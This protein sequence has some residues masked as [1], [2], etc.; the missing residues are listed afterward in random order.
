MNCWSE[1]NSAPFSEV[2]CVTEAGLYN[3]SQFWDVCYYCPLGWQ[4]SQT[5]PLVTE[6][7]C[8]NRRGHLLPFS[9]SGD[10]ESRLMH[11]GCLTKNIFI[12]QKHEKTPQ[13]GICNSTVQ[14][15]A[16]VSHRVVSGSLWHKQLACVC[17]SGSPPGRCQTSCAVT[18]HSEEHARA[19]Y[20]ESMGRIKCF[21]VHLSS[22]LFKQ[23]TQVKKLFWACSTDTS[24]LVRDWQPFLTCLW[25][26][27]QVM[28]EVASCCYQPDAV[29]PNPLQRYA[30]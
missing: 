14:H 11:S 29:K 3:T 9:A 6:P 21:P 25:E 27:F 17:S 10:K 12:Q 20:V 26:W 23:Q 22:A 5:F 28:A 19:C 18:H 13:S 16:A 4:S 15:F 1:L 24:A 8:C 7:K 30:F 2:L